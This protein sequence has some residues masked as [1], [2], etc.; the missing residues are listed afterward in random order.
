MS[1]RLTELLAK[2]TNAQETSLRRQQQ[3]TEAVNNSLAG[4][5][6][7]LAGV[8]D[9]MEQLRQRPDAYPTVPNEGA[10]QQALASIAQAQLDATNRNAHVANAVN[11]GVVAGA[12]GLADVAAGFRQMAQAPAA[13]PDALPPEQFEAAQRAD[14]LMAA[15]QAARRTSDGDDPL[16][17]RGDDPQPILAPAPVPAPAPQPVVLVCPTCQ[18]SGRVTYS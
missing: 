17:S 11:A 7:G 16:T 5:L 3:V 15:F 2:M 9:A 8:A 13:T 12:Q 10:R 6:G 1:D 4:G 18:G 14:R